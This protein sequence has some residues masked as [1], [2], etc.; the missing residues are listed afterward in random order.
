MPTLNTLVTIGSVVAGD[1][2]AVVLGNSTQVTKQQDG[3]FLI[4]LRLSESMTDEDL[5]L[6]D[7][8]LDHECSHV[9]FTNFDVFKNVKN[10]NKYLQIFY[11]FTF[12]HYICGEKKLIDKII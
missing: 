4:T 5:A 2:V 6:V 1:N 3:S 8:Y 12:L 10:N 9:R 7:G 11:L